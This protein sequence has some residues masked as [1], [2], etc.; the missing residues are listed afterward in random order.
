MFFGCSCPRSF[1]NKNGYYTIISLRASSSSPHSCE[2][3]DPEESDY[4]ATSSGD[5]VCD[6]QRGSVNMTLQRLQSM[7]AVATCSEK[8]SKYAENGRCKTRIRK[9]VANPI[10]QCH[11]NL[12]LHTLFRVCVAF[13]CLT[14]QGQD[15]V[16][17]TIQRENP[18]S[19]SKKDW[20]IEGQVS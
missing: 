14:K 20:F 6:F 12:P 18:G 8:T 2:T 15:T 10:C 3:S 11:C 5:D 16:L 17:W 9:S 7:H 19:G 13:W 4:S 1:S